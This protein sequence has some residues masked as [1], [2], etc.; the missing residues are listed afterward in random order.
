MKFRVHVVHFNESKFI[1]QSVNSRAATNL[2]VRNVNTCLI[3]TRIYR[4]PWRKYFILQFLLLLYCIST[5]I[6][7]LSAETN[8]MYWST[9]CCCS[10]KQPNF[11]FAYQLFSISLIKLTSNRYIWS[12]GSRSP[13]WSA[14]QKWVKPHQHLNSF[15]FDSKNY[16][17][18]IDD[19]PAQEVISNK[20]RTK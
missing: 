9:D 16:I 15:Y 11:M 3:Y 10:D 12:G 14:L 1:F 18:M 2:N 7:R 13:L 5:F 6:R 4:K 19:N 20:K 17:D 8:D